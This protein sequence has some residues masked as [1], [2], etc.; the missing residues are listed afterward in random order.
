MGSIMDHVVNS[1]SNTGLESN[2]GVMIIPVGVI[3]REV[4]TISTIR[5]SPVP[6]VS[7]VAPWLPG[8]AVIVAGLVHRGRFGCGVQ[9]AIRTTLVVVVVCMDTRRLWSN[10]NAMAPPWMVV[11]YRSLAAALECLLRWQQQSR[12]QQR[13]SC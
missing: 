6:T 12:L 10:V 8:V 1:M 7:P 11:I 3:I 13:S 2:I 5:I 4:A 9:L